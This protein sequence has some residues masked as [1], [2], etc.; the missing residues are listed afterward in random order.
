M[1]PRRRHAAAFGVGKSEVLASDQRG[2]TWDAAQDMRA[3]VPRLDESV[4]EWGAGAGYWGVER[5]ISVTSECVRAVGV[6]RVL[7]RWV[8]GL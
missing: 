8:E 1:N 2:R 5:R 3:E 7:N 6:D 4:G